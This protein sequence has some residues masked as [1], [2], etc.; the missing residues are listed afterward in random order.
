MLT[1]PGGVTCDSFDEKIVQLLAKQYLHCKM[2]NVESLK[3]LM[4][5][6]QGWQ[7]KR[8]KTAEMLKES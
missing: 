4:F 7:T 3:V 2:A 5:S 6:D 8:K 1:N